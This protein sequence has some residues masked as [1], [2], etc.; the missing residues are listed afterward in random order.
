MTAHFSCDEICPELTSYQHRGTSPTA[1]PPNSLQLQDRKLRSPPQIVAS[2]QY[3][4]PSRPLAFLRIRLLIRLDCLNHRREQL[5]FIEAR[6]LMI[7]V[8]GLEP[9]GISAGLH[10]Y[11]GQRNPMGQPCVKTHFALQ[12]PQRQVVTRYPQSAPIVQ[13]EV[14]GM[15]CGCTKITTQKKYCK[16]KRRQAR[17]CYLRFSESCRKL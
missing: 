7:S 17:C 5:S 4:T 16:R 1:K 6:R 13:F 15:K 11:I 2:A 3:A 10:V 8:E 9:P 14:F 12:P